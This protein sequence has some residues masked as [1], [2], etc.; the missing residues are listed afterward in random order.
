MRF[1]GSNAWG[2]ARED[3][4]YCGVVERA[5]EGI[6]A[7]A[8]GAIQVSPALQRWGWLARGHSAVGTAQNKSQKKNCAVPTGL[9]FLPFALPTLKHWANSC[10]PY[11]NPLSTCG[12]LVL[13]L[14]LPAAAQVTVG[15]NLSM[16]LNGVVS[17]GYNDNWGNM[18]DSSHSI[19]FGGNG[20]LSGFYYDPNFLNFNFSPYFNQSQANSASK[21]IF[22]TSGFEFSSNIFAGSHFPGSI[23]FSKA[24]DS[25]GNFGFPGTPDYTTRGS[26]QGF[27]IGWGAFLPGLP[28][29]SAT[30]SDGNSNYS[31]LG[32]E[33]NGSNVYHNFNL[34]SNYTIAGFNLNAA[35]DLGNSRSDIPAVFGNQA[36]SFSSDNNSFVVGASHNLPM[37]GSAS[38]SYSRSYVNSDYLGYSFNGTI[39]SVN[40]AAG[41]NPTQ[42]LSFA[43][44]M[45]YTDNFAGAFYQSLLPVSG[46]SSQGS[47]V[48]QAQTSGSSEPAQQQTGLLQ[49]SQE[50]SSALY[51]SGYGAYAVAPN[52]QLNFVV[53]RRVQNYLGLSYG[54]NTYGVGAVYSHALLGGFFNTSVNF[55]DNTSDT[56]NGDALSFTTNAGWNRTFSDWFVS[57]NG[58]YAQN[59]QSYL[60]TYMNSYYIYSGNVRHRFG[61][62]VWTASAAGSH[63]AIVYQPHTGNGGQSYST[64]L[65]ARHLTASAAYA[66]TNGYGLL[67]GN[68]IT[69]PPGLP[70]GVIPPEWL[71]FYGGTSYSFALGSSPIRHLT[72]GASFS[73][74][75]SNTVTGLLFSANH[76]EQVFANGY[77]QF[78]KLTFNGGYG[79]LVQ[80]FS[81]TGL[82]ASNVN[83]FYIGVS[84]YFNFF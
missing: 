46:A 68:G 23:G 6:E 5:F 53:Q 21:S 66:K 61:R 44:S 24:W 84:R 20:T 4:D 38:A 64:S 75:D 40:A 8:V 57:V 58:G 82:P 62:I 17:V 65:G 10:R 22:D 41:I 59:V 13:L 35:Y 42:K 56:I 63:S 7:S 3:Q 15:D 51:V 47:G 32:A 49:Q 54:A 33:G 50:S 77:Y 71:L 25:Q 83:S 11:G 19:N 28:S 26:G 30:Y 72:L 70:P 37:H 34:R 52:L 78:R 2:K 45:G 80:G 36:E 18:I 31:V 74:A 16:N 69:L 67:T 73:R 79:R 9:G 81:A 27:S 39:D 14:A 29:L 60:I 12:A 55:A 43:F 76:N 48:A 1:G